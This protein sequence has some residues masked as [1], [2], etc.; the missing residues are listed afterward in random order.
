MQPFYLPFFKG[1][2]SLNGFDEEDHEE[3]AE[4]LRKTLYY[5]KTPS[6]DRPSLP[7]TE[8]AVEYLQEA[9]PRQLGKLDIF[10]AATTSRQACM[11]P[12]SVMMSML[13]VK[14]LK[15]RNPAYL[16]Q[17]SSADL[18]LI[19][20]M[21]ASKFLYDEGIDDEVFNDE[22]AASADLETEEVNEMELQFLSAID[23]QLF[24][25]PNEFYD[26]LHDLEKRIALRQ[27]RERGWFTYTDLMVLSEDP[28]FAKLATFLSQEISKVVLVSS[29]AYLAS[30]LT[31][32]GSTLLVTTMTTAI[33]IHGPTVLAPPLPNLPQAVPKCLHGRCNETS[34]SVMESP[35]EDTVTVD[36]N[37]PEHEGSRDRFSVLKN[38]VDGLLS[39]F[40]VV[41]LR[42]TFAKHIYST[43]DNKNTYDQDLTHYPNPT[44]TAQRPNKSVITEYGGLFH[45]DEQAQYRLHGCASCGK[46]ES[47][48][49][50]ES[51]HVQREVN[52]ARCVVDREIVYVGF[53]DLMLYDRFSDISL[54]FTTG[55]KSPALLHT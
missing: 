44:E 20:V 45:S 3:F 48:G 2:D 39:L 28:E 42:D 43:K 29:V 41:S 15:T 34:F 14:R 1:N 54:G 12:C 22:W 18:F 55:L 17:I 52:P 25:R 47:N 32:V 31:M 8:I 11:S 37:T 9:C 30:V 6:T 51:G 33:M 4:R 38:T 50:K 49:N 35:V 13:Y 27:A 10:S 46:C 23:W 36:A 5:G 19:S 16:Q 26:I 53:K 40:T 24:V 21:M 7:L